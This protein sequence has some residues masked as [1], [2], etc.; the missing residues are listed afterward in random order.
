MQLNFTCCTLV[1]IVDCF[2]PNVFNLVFSVL[3]IFRYGREDERRTSL[4]CT[5]IFHFLLVLI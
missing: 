3:Y 1:L 4:F 5:S 2:N